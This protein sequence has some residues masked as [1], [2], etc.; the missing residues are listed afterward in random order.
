MSC[1]EPLK[2]KNELM[3]ID[4]L[5]DAQVIMLTKQKTSLSKSATMD[6]KV[7]NSVLEIYDSAKWAQELDVF[8]QLA[9]VNRPVYV[10]KYDVVDNI[11]DA[12]SNLRILSIS[13]TENLPI[14]FL[15][16]YYQDNKSKVRKIEG[17]YFES[18]S[19]F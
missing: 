10:D 4:S 15:K 6:G 8:R 3:A 7:S 5:L 2:S 19:I 9:M 14:S 1:Q 17:S 11:E 12:N 16:V 13:T 18:N